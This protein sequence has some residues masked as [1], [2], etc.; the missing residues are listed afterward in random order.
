MQYIRDD[1]PNPARRQLYR[2][3]LWITLLGNISLAVGKTIAAYFSGSAAL[4]ADAVNSISDVAYSLLMVVALW[5]AQQ[6]PDLSHPQ[7]HSRFEPL[8]G[9]VVAAAMTFA[10][11][12][13]GRVSIQRF[14]QTG[15]PL[16][17]GWPTLV[18]LGGAAIK[19][20][21]Y[22]RISTL[23][24]AAYSSMLKDAARDN[25]S[26][27]L[28][29]VAAFV[30]MWGAAWIHPRVDAIAGLLVA[31]WIFRAAFQAWRENLRYLTGA[32]ASEELRQKVTQA[33]INVPEVLGVHQVILE[34][35]GPQLIADLH[36]DVNGELSLNAAH[37]IADEVQKHLERFPEI[38][39][40]YVHVEPKAASPSGKL[41]HDLDTRSSS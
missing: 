2:Q 25:L 40:T 12:K 30:G 9:L 34:Y 1:S 10:G 22:W 4:Y 38:D 35:A 7:G 6:P 15:G 19:A 33:I 26:D 27:V 5:L 23:A 29:S 24:K 8:A 11:Y 37:I 36:I 16:P 39:R 18:L 21:M 41:Q 3:A 14:W 13:A 28:T 31:L 32:G 20:G 17:I